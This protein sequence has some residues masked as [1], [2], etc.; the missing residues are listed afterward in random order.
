MNFSN[1]KKLRKILGLILVA[2]MVA[3]V[4]TGCKR[5]SPSE[6]T[7][8]TQA[9]G[10]NLNLNITE[11]T[12][13]PTVPPE[14]TVPTE[15]QP[16]INENTGVALS[17]INVR[18]NPHSDSLV[19]ATLAAGDRIEVSRRDTALGVE[20]AYIVS[21]TTGWIMMDYVKMD[22]EQQ[23][24]ANNTT[25]PAGNGDVPAPTE[26]TPT[27]LGTKGVITGN[28]LYVRSEPNTNG[29]VQGSYN[30]GDTV[31]ILEQQNGWGRTNKGWINLNYV[32]LEGGTTGNGANTN[33]NTWGSAGNSGSANGTTNV[34]GNGSTTVQFRGIVTAGELN[35]RREARQDSD[36]LGSLKYGARV[37]ILEKNGTWGRTKDGWISLNYV[38]QDGTTGTNTATGTVTGDGLRIRSGPGTGYGV[39]GSYNSG[40]TVNILEQFT[41]GGTAWGCTNKG[42]ICMDYVSVD[43]GSSTN[44][45]VGDNNNGS[46][47]WEDNSSNTDTDVDQTGTVTATELRVRA[48][49]G[50]QYQ[51]VAGLRYGDR[52][53]V[54]RTRVVDGVTWGEIDAGWISMSYVNL[55]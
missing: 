7:P 15:P 47:A 20:W 1:Q 6:T 30:K 13:A 16:E 35:I 19:I 48:G 45:W 11:P 49:A 23:A 41:Y 38:Y 51:V 2:C 18:S 26:G 34:T 29:K 24:P 46:S 44:T 32:T 17:A 39:V 53:T 36:R 10:L 28:G 54:H 4:F 3:V 42:W 33:T 50:T 5:K 52:V 9:P 14:T 22:M 27:V 8:P 31:T 37:E 55:D 21:P 12:V 43:G 40:T 25:T